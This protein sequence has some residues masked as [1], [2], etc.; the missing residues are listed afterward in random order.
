MI[1][2]DFGHGDMAPAVQWLQERARVVFADGIDQAAEAAL[3]EPVELCVFAQARPGRFCRE[4]VERLHR[5]APLARLAV[6]LGAWCEGEQRT[7]KPLEGALRIYWHEWRTKLEPYWRSESA[8]EAAAWSLPRTALTGERTLTAAVSPVTNDR[9]LIAI[10]ALNAASFSSLAAACQ[11]CGYAAVWLDPQQP[12]RAHAATALLW[13]GD[14]R[15]DAACA[16]LSRLA[17][18]L[19]PATTIA[20]V[21]FPRREDQRRALAAGAVEM[22]G[23]PFLLADLMRLLHRGHH[24]LRGEASSRGA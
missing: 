4:D 17:S 24:A 16:E 3:R 12:M 5:A 22:M 19:R 7:G 8:S 15:R 6:L 11:S 21:N 13:E 2:G 9:A 18:A 1:V 10:R 14:V 20:L 23:K